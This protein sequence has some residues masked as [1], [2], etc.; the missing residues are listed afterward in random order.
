[1]K[2]YQQLVKEKGA[3]PLLPG[4]NYNQNQLFFINSA[5]IFCAKWKDQGL[6]TYMLTDTHSNPEFR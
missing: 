3:E 1:M 6:L 5:Q 4:L 2:A